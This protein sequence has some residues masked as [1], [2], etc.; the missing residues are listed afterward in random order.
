MKSPITGKEMTL[1]SELRT[2]HYKGNDITYK[3]TFY[4][5]GVE[6]FTTTELDEQNM[7]QINKQHDKKN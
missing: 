4:F 2:I 3:H 7:K 6:S 5:D 1:K